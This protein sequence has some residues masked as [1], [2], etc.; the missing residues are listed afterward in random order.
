MKQPKLKEIIVI[1]KLS[2][3]NIHQILIEKKASKLLFDFI[4]HLSG[5]TIKLNETDL[6]GELQKYNNL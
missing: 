2:N 5:G 3:G 6:Y 4:V 1:G